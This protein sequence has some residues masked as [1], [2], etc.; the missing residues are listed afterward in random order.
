[1]PKPVERSTYVLLASL[2]L[3]L[4]FWQWRPMP[5][6]LWDAQSP[7]ARAALW[8]LFGLGWAIVLL[9]T[10]MINHFDLFGLRQVYLRA[11]GIDYTNVPF[12][13]VAFY[14]FVRHPIMLGA[15]SSRSG[16]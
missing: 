12:K 7:W 2:A 11:R 6:L 15:S 4:L 5:T 10:F 1:M 16:T 8:A 14:K 13:T 9:S 3:A